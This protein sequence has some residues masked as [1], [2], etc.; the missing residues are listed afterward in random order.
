V[1]TFSL[2]G[3]GGAPFFHFSQPGRHNGLATLRH[4]VKLRLLDRAHDSEKV[5]EF[6]CTFVRYLDF[7]ISIR[8]ILKCRSE[9]DCNAR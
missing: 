1:R 8:R 3:L 4:F 2:H 6:I 9:S 5:L 7:T